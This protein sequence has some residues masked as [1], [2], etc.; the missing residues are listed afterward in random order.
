MGELMIY[1]REPGQDDGIDTIT[2]SQR[3]ALH[4]WFRLFAAA[5]N[6]AGIDQRVFFESFKEGIS[7]PNTEHNIKAAFKTVADAMYGK[8]H[9][10]EL[11]TKQVTELWEV[12]SREMSQ[13]LGVFVPFPSDEPP[14]IGE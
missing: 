1:D 13:R 3:N 8:D 11:D 5:L 6:E 12:F 14:M 10:E 2:Q 7:V 9:T 4:L